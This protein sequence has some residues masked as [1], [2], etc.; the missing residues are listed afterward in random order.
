M[1]WQ[2]HI[3]KKYAVCSETVNWEA[4]RHHRQS[5]NR[6]PSVYLRYF[7]RLLHPHFLSS[8]P[9]SPPWASDLSLTSSQRSS[10]GSPS[11]KE[12]DRSPIQIYKWGLHF[13]PWVDQSM[14]NKVF[15]VVADLEKRRLT[16]WLQEVLGCWTRWKESHGGGAAG[17]RGQR[18]ADPP[19]FCV[20]VSCLI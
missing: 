4:L 10:S 17:V 2:P 3:S 13:Q 16:R 11:E 8:P 14:L 12:E 6:S 5:A 15:R 19:A 9:S 18:T 1:E 20:G 7:L